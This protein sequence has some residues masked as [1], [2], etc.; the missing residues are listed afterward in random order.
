MSIAFAATA[1]ATATVTV[2]TPYPSFETALQIVPAEDWYRTWSAERTIMLRMTSKRVREAVDKMRP[3]AVVCL[4]RKYWD[5]FLAKLEFVM[6]QLLSL[7]TNC[8]IT[9][10]KLERCNIDWKMQELKEVLYQC[11]ELNK[12]ELSGNNFTDGSLV[13]AL[14]QC[15]V[16][17]HT[18]SAVCGL[19]SLN[20]ECCNIGN[21]GAARFANALS[22]FSALS[23][24]NLKGN[25]I[26]V[27]GAKVLAG[28]LGQCKAL[29]SLKL[30]SNEI[31]NGAIN[32]IKNLPQCST[33]TELD[34][35]R[36]YIDCTFTVDIARNLP[37]CVALAHFDL[38]CNFIRARGAENIAR[39][40]GQCT[41]LTY[42][43]LKDNKMSES[44]ADYTSSLL[45]I[46]S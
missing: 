15:S 1:A 6:R 5:N 43:N 26:G 46:R 21:Y 35:S 11:P 42:L 8:R 31:S 34:L 20:L 40:L 22:E 17:P 10:L 38:S 45:H 4:C 33:L 30:G 29:T 24:L 13:D 44:I 7:V 25:F 36:N 16:S 32:I 9:T 37:Q 2:A 12:L 23:C 41:S 39:V 28:V 19:I 27:E 3:P 14:M 18:N